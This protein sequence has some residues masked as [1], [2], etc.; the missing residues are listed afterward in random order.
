MKKNAVLMSCFFLCVMCLPAAAKGRAPA[1]VTDWKSAFPDSA[2]IA[3]RGTGKTAELARTDAISA[4]A[5]YLK[6]E[7][8]ATL[9]TSFSTSGSE[10]RTET[11]EDVLITSQ[12][13][14]YGTEFTEP[15]L[16]KKTWC[17][18]A[19]IDRAKAWAQILPGIRAKEAV[20]LSF[21]EKAQA[22][23]EPFRACACYKDAWDSAQ[24]FFAALAYGRLIYPGADAV[25]A[26]SKGRA[27]SVPSL[28]AAQKAGVSVRIVCPE[29]ADGII[30]N[31]VAR[32]FEE[33]GFAVS[34][35][36]C[37]AAEA[38]IEL[39]AEGGDPVAVRPSL[40][41][42]VRGRTGAAVHSFQCR[43]EEKT[44]AYSLETAKRRALP[45]LAEAVGAQFLQGYEGIR[46]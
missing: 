25:F 27:L 44:A 22:D 31:A 1:W 21:M 2:Y 12:A 40:T 33:A 42:T 5:R 34:D 14:L 36:G 43:A 41:V 6:S 9:S 46:P 13:E 26:E 16:Y 11:Q 20:F 39:N 30:R 37:C 19:Y 3:Q 7:V 18:V 29:D 10:E 32:K 35:D 24:D 23:D 28:L 38:K 17:C 45:K 4:V 8:Q 15:Y